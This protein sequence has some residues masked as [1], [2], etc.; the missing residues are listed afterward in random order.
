MFVIYLVVLQ[1]CGGL[2]VAIVVK[3]ADNLLKGFATS[4]AIILSCAVSIILFD[5]HLTLQFTF[6]TLLVIASIFLYGYQPSVA[7]KSS[8]IAKV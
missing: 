7:S 6:G 8:I 4:V 2:L 1:A 5:F 3:Y